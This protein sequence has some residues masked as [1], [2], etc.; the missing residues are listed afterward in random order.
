M[1]ITWQ[2]HNKTLDKLHRRGYVHSDVREPNLLFSQNGT[3][4]I[5]FDFDLM[6]KVDTVYPDGFN[7]VSER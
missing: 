5:L 2:L 3:D 7:G 1:K 4:V 6:D